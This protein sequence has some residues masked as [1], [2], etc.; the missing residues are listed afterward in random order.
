MS[1]FIPVLV[2]QFPV[3]LDIQYNLDVILS[4]LS[5]AEPNTLVIL[6]EGALSGY[7]EDTE[8]LSKINQQ[9]LTLSLRKLQET[10]TQSNIHLVFGSC[11]LEHGKWYN[12]GIYYGP[13]QAQFVYRKVNLATSERAVFTAGS[14]LSVVELDISG[15]R[16]KLGIQLCREIRFPEQWQYLARRGADIFVYLTNA[17]GDATQAPVWRSHLI[18]RAAENQRFVMCANNAHVAQKCPS[19]IVTPTGSVA[20]EACSSEREVKNYLIDP[21]AVSDWYLSQ[22][23]IDLFT[24]NVEH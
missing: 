24:S 13:Q 2:A 12:A 16:I 10:A 7:A 9:I 17:V 18:S 6:P 14:Q 8:F 21:S 19:M 11:L 5:Q 15:R 22:S 20:W 1:N 3:T 23:R 4:I